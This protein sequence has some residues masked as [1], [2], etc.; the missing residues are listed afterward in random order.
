MIVCITDWLVTRTIESVFTCENNWQ[1][2]K[3]RFFR[4][5]YL[6]DTTEFESFKWK[7]EFW[8]I[9]PSTEASFF[10]YF[11]DDISNDINEYKVIVFYNEK[12]QYLETA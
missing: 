7:L 9:L 5:G 1:T 11:S 12:C 2:D 3:Q 10:H 6:V 4:L 8:K